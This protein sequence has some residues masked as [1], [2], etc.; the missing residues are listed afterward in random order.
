MDLYDFDLVVSTV[1]LNLQGIAWIKVSP[2]LEDNDILA[3]QKIFLN[4]RKQKWKHKNNGIAEHTAESEGA[5]VLELQNIST[6]A[7]CRDWQSAIDAAGGL[8]EKQ[9]VITAE[10]I[11]GMKEAVEKYGAYCVFCPGVALV[12]ASPENGVNRF[13]LS[14]VKLRE[15]VCFGHA[16]NDPVLWVICLASEER[17]PRLQ[18]VLGIMN[19]M[20]DP[21]M[22]KELD[23]LTTAQEVLQYL[24]DRKME[25]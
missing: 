16:S 2:M 9:G 25:E 11:Q 14:L 21:Q 24:I 7:A 20:S 13:G 23:K 5:F 12:H 19:L 1:K 8:L 17:N 22:R 3:L 10:Y 15:P 4:L 18:Q 6:D